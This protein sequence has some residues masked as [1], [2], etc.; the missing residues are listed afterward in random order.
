VSRAVDVRIVAV[1]CLVFN[2]GDVDGY[3]ALS[4]FRCLVD[5]VERRTFCSASS[6]KR[7]RDRRCQRRLAVVD[8]TYRPYVEMRLVSYKFSFAISVLPP[9]RSLPYMYT[10]IFQ[11]QFVFKI[12]IFAWSGFSIK[13]CCYASHKNQRVTLISAPEAD[14]KISFVFLQRKRKRIKISNNGYTIS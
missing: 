5:H 4:F 6:G 11:Q 12:D 1:L 7:L 8:M 3:S 10:L 2:V 14:F 13:Y 9:W